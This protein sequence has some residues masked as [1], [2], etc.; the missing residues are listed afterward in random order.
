MKLKENE[1]KANENTMNYILNHSDI[2]YVQKVLNH[3][4]LIYDKISSEN[5]IN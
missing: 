2:F 5:Q 1:K 3:E 4:K